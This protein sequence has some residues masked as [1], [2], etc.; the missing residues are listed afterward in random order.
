MDAFEKLIA[1][2]LWAEGYWVRTSVRVNLTKEEKVRIGRYSS[3]R[4]ELDVVR[5]RGRRNALQVIECK[6]YL[7]SRGVTLAVSEQLQRRSRQPF[8]TIRR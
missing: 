6:S 8:Q 7:D 4:W 5:Y 2:I 3:P 1:E